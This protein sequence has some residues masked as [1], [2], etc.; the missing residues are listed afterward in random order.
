MALPDV[1]EIHP[2]EAPGPARLRAPGSKSITNRALIRAA[3]CEGEVTLRGALW[4]EDTQV[5]V[6]CLRALGVAIA[7]EVEVDEPSNRTLR[8]SGRGGRLREGGSAADPLSIRVANAGT[9]AR[10]LTAL[11][12]LGR[13]CYRLHGSERMHERPQRGLVR[14][15]RQLGY[16]IDS[17]NDRL[18]LVVHGAGALSGSCEVDISESSQFA[19]ALLLCADHG[20]W[21]VRVIGE[22]GDD[23][24]YVKLTRELV[25][26]FPSAGGELR[27]E[28]DSSSGSY[29]EAARFLF[30]E[31]GIEVLDWPTSDWQ[32]D[33]AFP[34]LLP[35]R[36]PLSRMHD[37]GDS[38]MTAIVLAPLAESPASFVDLGRLRVQE[39][40]RVAALRTELSKCGARV[41]ESGDRLEIQPSPLHG[42]EIETYED[43]RMAMCFATLGLAV[44]GM[45]IRNPECVR[46]TFPSFYL[47][48]GAPAPQGLGA[49][50]SDAATGR[51]LSQAELLLE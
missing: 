13:G 20:G 36:R 32:V 5:M 24:P 29:L 25:A 10:G 34:R 12:C 19:S 41:V 51:L 50:I 16:R 14:A 6:E 1:I 11:L 4:S 8:V 9:A 7:I 45:R 38:I 2:L 27:V 18:P 23:S 28:M 46:K 3:L 49:G 44:R 39:C 47:K 42:A 15:L 31:A 40:E 33:S 37:L 22:R 43:H 17:E 26:Q 30:P 21:Q 48:L 35:L